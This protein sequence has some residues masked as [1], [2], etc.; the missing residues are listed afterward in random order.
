MGDFPAAVS[1]LDALETDL[2][3][4]QRRLALQW[5]MAANDWPRAARLAEQVEQASSDRAVK[6]EARLDRAVALRAMGQLDT[7]L[8]L[9]E[10]TAG[11]GNAGAARRAVVAARALRQGRGPLS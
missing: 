4:E 2:S 7:A 5:S 1:G 8:S 6:A 10:L 11:P 9:F 3:P